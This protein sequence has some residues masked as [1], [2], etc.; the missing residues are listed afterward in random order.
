MERHLATHEQNSN[1]DASTMAIVTLQ[2]PVGQM[3][4]PDG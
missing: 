2:D 4:D 1:D 3:A